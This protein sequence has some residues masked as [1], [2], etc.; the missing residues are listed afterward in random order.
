MEFEKNT[1]RVWRDPPCGS[2]PL[3]RLPELKAPTAAWHY[4]LVSG[5]PMPRTAR[6][7][8]PFF[9]RLLVA[10][11]FASR[12]MLAPR[13]WPPK[14]RTG[15]DSLAPVNFLAFIVVTITV[16]LNKPRAKIGTFKASGS[17]Q[18][19]PIGITLYSLPLV[20]VRAARFSIGRKVHSLTV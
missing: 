3:F 17:R 20:L 19:L 14:W 13:T 10:E 2:L 5:K 6:L 12:L 4:R 15:T 1:F 9:I 18:L 16:S 8:P 11:A 7:Q